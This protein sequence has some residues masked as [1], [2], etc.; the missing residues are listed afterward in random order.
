M[1]T[2]AA[3]RLA[4]QLFS[5]AMFIVG[6]LLSMSQEIIVPPTEHNSTL[7][8]VSEA[9]QVRPGFE[10]RHLRSWPG[11]TL[12][13]LSELLCEPAGGDSVTDGHLRHSKQSELRFQYDAAVAGG[14]MTG[15]LRS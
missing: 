12:L 11:F 1:V 2:V 10:L 5:A 7:C 9:E 4:I 15:E 8:T 3:Q 6:W 14:S 13:M